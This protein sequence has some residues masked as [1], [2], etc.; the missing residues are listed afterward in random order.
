MGKAAD[1]GAGFD[2]V[3]HRHHHVQHHHRHVFVLPQQVHRLPAVLGF[4]DLIAGAAQIIP[5]DH[6]PAGVVIGKQD[7]CPHGLFSFGM[8]ISQR[9]M[10]VPRAWNFSS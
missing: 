6:A 9:W 3:H 4:E 8:V 5:D 2:A 7:L 1:L 10:G